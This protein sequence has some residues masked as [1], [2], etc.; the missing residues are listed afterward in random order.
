M[1][2]KA[3]LN[4]KKIEQKEFAKKIGVHPNTLN[5]YLRWRTTPTAE[6]IERIYKA[7]GRKVKF[8]DIMKYWGSR[9]KNEI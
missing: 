2:L 1:D 8:K 3:Y 6:I 7:T 5:N 4:L 9:K